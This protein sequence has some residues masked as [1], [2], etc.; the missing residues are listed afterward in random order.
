MAE[1]S[2]LWQQAVFFL[3][4]APIMALLI[5]LLSRGWATIVQGGNVSEKTIKRQR[6]EFW[7]VLI[8]MYAMLACIF[9]YAHLRH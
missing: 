3:L 7:V 1:A 5:R 9:G 2:P 4:A 8:F 6:L